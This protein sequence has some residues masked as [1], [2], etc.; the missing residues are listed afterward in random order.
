MAQVTNALVT[1]TDL[2]QM[3]LIAKVGTV[4]PGGNQCATKSFIDTYYNVDT[5]ASPYSGYT[6]NRLPRYQDILPDPNAFLV[7]YNLSIA[8]FGGAGCNGTGTYQTWTFSL[9]DQFGAAFYA[10]SPITFTISYDYTFVED[11][12]PF[13]TNGTGSQTVTINTGQYTNSTNVTLYQPEFCPFS[14]ACDG[15]CYYNYTNHYVSD[16]SPAMNGGCSYPTGTCSYV[17]S[18]FPSNFT[19][20]AGSPTGYLW[21]WQAKNSGG[22]WEPFTYSCK[23]NTSWNIFSALGTSV[24]SGTSTTYVPWNGLFN[25]STF[26]AAGTYFFNVDLGDGSGVQS[27]KIIKLF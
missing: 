18:L 24:Y 6:S 3:N 7:C 20:D 25:N 23:T 27:G 15:T 8:S 16:V 22:T 19:A 12:P 14:S 1:Y 9:V 13:V 11:I 10:T 17:Q 4:P 5:G 21:Q 2:Q 26:L